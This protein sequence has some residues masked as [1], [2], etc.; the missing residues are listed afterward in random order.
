MDM[1]LIF[2]LVIGLIL[3]YVIAVYNKLV[4]LR[5][6]VRNDAKQIDVQLDRRFKVFESLII[7]I[8]ASNTLR[9]NPIGLA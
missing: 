3:F 6:A 2:L 1:G 7:S 4:A 8:L 9:K 5:E